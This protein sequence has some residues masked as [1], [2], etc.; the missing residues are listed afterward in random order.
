MKRVKLIKLEDRC[1]LPDDGDRLQSPKH[2]VFI[3]KTELDNVQQVCHRIL[4]F[5]YICIGGTYEK[6][7]SQ[8][9]I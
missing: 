7:N 5:H 4:S 8:T 9:Q 1:L 6:L 2:C 3:K